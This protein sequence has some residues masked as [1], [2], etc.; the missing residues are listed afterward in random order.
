M[1]RMGYLIA[2]VLITALLC[3]CEPEILPR[4]IVDAQVTSGFTPDQRR[5]AD[6]II[7][8]F[9]NNTSVIQYDY[10]ENLDDGRGITAGRAGFTSA[11]GDMLT[12]V[13]QYT[14]HT[15]DTPLAAYLPALK[16]LAAN[17]DGSTE[18]LDGLAVE[19][20]VAASDP[21][22][23][24]VQDEIVDMEYYDPAVAHANSIG[25]ISPL[26]LLIIYDAAIQH[27]NG[28]DADGLPAMIAKT[29]AVTG[30]TVADGIDEE[31]WVQEFLRVRRA[32]LLNPTASETQI[33][34]SES[35]GRVDTLRT[36]YESGNIALIPP[37]EIDTWGDT[38]VLE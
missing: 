7:S 28:E 34:W 11:T 21:A 24:A 14:I 8:I 29:T 15:P 35:V 10:A 9:E 16:G 4:A 18:R 12:V 32:V 27:G 5:I 25:L 2:S 31:A 23:R 36:F 1:R 19:W 3:G 38:F 13:E 26:S 30:G 17:E 22:F 6:Q 33:E 20:R 37:I